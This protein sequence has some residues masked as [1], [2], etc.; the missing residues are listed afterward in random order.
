MFVNNCVAV[1]NLWLLANAK[2]H[3]DGT[4]VCLL[5]CLSVY[6]LLWSFRHRTEKQSL[7]LYL[8]NF[9]SIFDCLW[10]AIVTITTVGYGDTFPVTLVGKIVAAICALTGVVVRV[11]SCKLHMCT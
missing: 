7:S 3:S 10:W 11:F 8:L 1:V 6:Y 5:T 2:V 9:Q 4:Y